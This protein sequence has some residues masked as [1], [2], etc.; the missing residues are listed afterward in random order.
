MDEMMQMYRMAK[1]EE[2]LPSMLD[3]TL[4]LNTDSPL[5]GKIG[6]MTKTNSEKAEVL[7]AYV[8]RLALLSHRKLTA[9]EMQ[10]FLAES[11][12]LL[13]ELAR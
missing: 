5:I 12:R 13:D 4:V 8:W 6:H 7:A 1:G 9:D 11:Y 10:A 2:E 3:L